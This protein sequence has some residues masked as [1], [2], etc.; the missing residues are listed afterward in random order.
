M[1]TTNTSD[2]ARRILPEESL[3]IVDMLMVCLRH[4]PWFI[5]SVLLCMGAATLYL[6]HTPKTFTR[7]TSILVKSS[8]NKSND[9]RLIE[10]LGVN[11][12]SSDIADEIVAIHS[13][14]VV[15]D[16]VKRLRL[17]FSYYRPGFFRDDVLYATTLPVEVEID[18]LED[19]TTASFQLT[20]NGDGSA[21]LIDIVLRG[22][23]VETPCRVAVGKKCKSPLGVI[24]VKPTL[25]YKKDQQADILVRR[26]GFNAAASRYGGM[27]TA[28][29]Q[30]G[31]RN[32]IDVRC[33]DTSIP[34]AENIL[35]T[36]VNIYNEN[37]VQNR[38]QVSVS[39]NEFIKERLAVIESE[40]GDV[41]GTI[42]SY[43]SSH[44][45]LS[46]EQA[47]SQ[48]VGK[49]AA[50]DQQRQ[51]ISNQLYMIRYVRNYVSD[52]SHAKQLMPASTG[53]GNSAIEGQIAAY[54][55]RILERN[56]LVS[57]SSEQNPLV[58]DLDQSLDNLR[59]AI[60]NS[61]DN[62][63]MTL[64]TQ[65]N[66]V[67]AAH[68]A[69]LSRLT[70]APQQKNHLL[71]FE[72]QQ[73]VKESLY[74]FLLQK[75]EE[76]ELSQ[77]FTAYN[78]RIIANPYGSSVPTSPNQ[79]Q[80]LLIAFALALAVPAA[81]FILRENLNSKVRGR[82]DL[83]NLS[84]PYVG[85]LPLWKPKKGEETTTDGYRFVVRQHSRDIVNEAYRVVRTNLEFMT[86]QEKQCKIIML[87][88]F[89]PGS[90]KTFITANL[91]ATF[92]IR[93]SR[94]ICID[95][96]LRRG[97]LSEFVDKPKH[98]LTS[99]LGGRTDTYADLIVHH[100]LNGNGDG[101]AA[102]I[103][104]LPMGKIPPN[105][106]ELLYSPKLKPMLDELRQQYDYIFVDCPPV[107]IVADATIISHEADVTLF[108]VRAGL[109]ERT[110]LPE[111]QKNYDEKKYNNMA[112]ILNGTDAEH[113]YGYRRY[114]YGYGRYGYG[115][116]YGY[117]YYGS[118]SSSSH[119]SKKKS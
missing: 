77:A 99:Y 47:A 2:I 12:I 16:L 53:I 64:N 18:S 23:T 10:A 71:S 15:Y 11:N 88:S 5:L 81:F 19:N 34:R 82:K 104:F 103:D 107:E 94:V 90:G 102:T 115:K 67:Q 114:G 92:A 31:T 118:S 28:S 100:E 96:D 37:W 49:E 33:V 24:T 65:M 30:P 35:K 3:S 22:E 61:L 27:I 20:L 89:N 52:P 113:H 74:L 14:A 42:A 63:Q 6:L 86:N 111:L 43:K 29:L 36:V 32:I 25:Y 109:L 98:G 75:R 72:R 108:V 57:N 91:G 105:P 44:G 80:I 117:G 87:T 54:N 51:A 48:A 110:M 97:S 46:V 70:A 45:M 78:T 56:N 59:G 39:T 76:N 9:I 93:G 73:K 55:N 13:P 8:G 68:G 83:E 50:A 1:S 21:T 62:A 69:A 84:V 26:T 116:R 119:K 106:T 85:E 101:N 95:L 60:L 17:D 38:N 41:E 112:M 7:T 4:W 66:T 40:L 79:N 58:T